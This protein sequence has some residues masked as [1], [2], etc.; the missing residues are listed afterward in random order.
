MTIPQGSTSQDSPPPQ[1]STPRRLKRYG[2]RRLYDPVRCRHLTLA[3]LSQWIVEGIDFVIVD[4]ET[5]VD[6]THDL[7]PLKR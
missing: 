2:R 3:D 7:L 1:N 6:V 4:A 5:G